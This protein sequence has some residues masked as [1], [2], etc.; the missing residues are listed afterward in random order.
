MRYMILIELAASKREESRNIQRIMKERI[1]NAL[2]K[3]KSLMER[4][5]EVY[6]CVLS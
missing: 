2:A 6:I 5:D 3:R 1:N 4:H